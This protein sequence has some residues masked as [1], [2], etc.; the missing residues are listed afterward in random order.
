MHRQTP[1]TAGFVGYTG[2]GARALVD[3]IDDSTGM[4]EMKGDFLHAEARNRVESPQNYGFTSVVLPALK[5]AAGKILECAEA[6]LQFLGGNRSF[7]TALV[8]DDRRHRPWGMKPGENAQYDDLGQMTILRRTGLYLL[9]LDGPDSTQQSSNGGTAP[10]QRD[11]NSSGQGQTVERMV[12]LRHVEKSKQP[13]PTGK[14]SGSQGSGGAAPGTQA[15]SGSSGGQGSSGQDFKHEGE[16]VNT[17]IRCTKNRIEFRSGDSVVGYYDKGADTWY[18]KGNI[19]SM[20]A[21]TRFETIGKT[22][23]GLDATQEIGPIVETVA[24]PAKQTFAKKGS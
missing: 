4:Q 23:L 22:Y 13:R 11:G 1:L 3:A 20:E 19:V 2:G 14:S 10:G 16:S 5:D 7:P 18:F 12:S 6:Y 24:G 9:S 17:E 8:M 21:G 15:D